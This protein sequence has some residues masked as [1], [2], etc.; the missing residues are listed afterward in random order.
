VSNG[1]LKPKLVSSVSAVPTPPL[2]TGSAAINPK[3]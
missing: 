1:V 2:K 3:A